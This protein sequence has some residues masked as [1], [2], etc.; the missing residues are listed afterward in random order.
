[1]L[2]RAY[3]RLEVGGVIHNDVTLWRVDHMPYAG[4]KGSGLGR[5][6]LRYAIE[7]QT[8]PR[9]LVLEVDR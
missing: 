4:V 3:A 8:E 5:E 2:H 6:G 9:L 1:M 7:W